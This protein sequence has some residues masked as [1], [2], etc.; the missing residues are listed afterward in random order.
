MLFCNGILGDVSV[1]G[2]R[3]KLKKRK[4][5]RCETDFWGLGGFRGDCV[6]G[7]WCD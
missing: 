7:V 2:D 6:V 1:C 4:N 5:N 3:S